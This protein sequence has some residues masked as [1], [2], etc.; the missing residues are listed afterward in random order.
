MGK[1]CVVF[2]AYQRAPQ[3]LLYDNERR[4]G[5]HPPD[6]AA[7]IR[8]RVAEEA[9][10]GWGMICRGKSIFGPNLDEK[11]TGGAALWIAERADELG[12]RP[13]NA[14]ERARAMG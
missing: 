2:S 10:E 9:R 13:P 12:V 7:R 6:V 11:A 8:A 14:G 5:V 4:N 3:H 1:G